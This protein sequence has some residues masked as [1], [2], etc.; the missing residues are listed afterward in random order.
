M[1]ITRGFAAGALFAGLA[2]VLTA[3]VSSADPLDGHYLET[4]TYPDGTSVG[5]PDNW[6]ITPCGDG[7]ASIKDRGQANLV[8]GQW[9]LDGKG[10]V[11]CEEGGGAPDAIAFH[12]SWDPNTLDGTVKIT[13]NVAACGNPQGYQETNK[14]HLELA[15]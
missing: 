13:N 2:L 10:P 15:T 14:L 5:P 1:T 11:S 9:T 4:E 3:P 7:C 12:Y 8:D 6:F